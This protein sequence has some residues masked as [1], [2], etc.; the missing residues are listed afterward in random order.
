MSSTLFT[1]PG[2]VEISSIVI[3]TPTKKEITITDLVLEFNIFETLHSPILKGSMMVADAAGILSNLPI[4]GQERVVFTYRRDDVEHEIEMYTTNI[5]KIS[6]INEYGLSYIIN[7]VHED[8]LR[9]A[10]SLISRSYV[11]SIHTMMELIAEE[12]LFNF[13]EVDETAGNFRF[14]IPNWTPYKTMMW[15]T[16]R[17]RNT[18][19]IP[20][21]LY[22]SLM[23]GME[24]RCLQTLFNDQQPVDTFYA[25]LKDTE[26]PE[27][28]AMIG[29]QALYSE[30]MRTASVLYPLEI[31]PMAEVL[32]GGAYSSTTM[33]VD[34]FEKTYSTYQFNYKEQFENMP[35]LGKFAVP[36][37]LFLIDDIPVYEHYH[38][39]QKTYAHS[40][41]SFGDSHIDYTG[42]SIDS[43]PFRQSYLQAL[44]NYRYR[45]AIPG[46]FDLSVGSLVN[47][48]VNKNRVPD[49]NDP[50]EWVDKRRS[51]THL[52]TALR[53]QFIP[54][55]SKYTITMDIARDTM[56]EDHE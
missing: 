34:L 32:Q 8:Y 30:Y 2:T 41:M 16:R 51:G 1:S 36:A 4:V 11:G 19:N 24:F 49:R 29:S 25:K 45:L 31:A 21:V 40:S 20:F 39:T 14:V 52:V 43:V 18:E 44:N 50:E 53:H 15:L 9:N 17:G 54:S 6:N 23:R 27:K 28:S 42:S 10:V 7:L 13:M 47:I 22:N 46:R 38:T 48:E 5:E 26:T 3:H 55:S 33:L 56:D 37:D 12:Y 35:H